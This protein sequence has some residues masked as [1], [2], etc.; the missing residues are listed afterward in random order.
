MEKQKVH[1]LTIIVEDH[2]DFLAKFHRKMLR[3]NKK[4]IKIINNS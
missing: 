3:N 1:I 2:C 4:T